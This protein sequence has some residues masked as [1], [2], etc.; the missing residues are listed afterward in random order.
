MEQFRLLSSLIDGLLGILERIVKINSIRTTQ[1]IKAVSPVLEI[2]QLP[3]GLVQ[4]VQILGQGRS[5]D[6][7]DV[8]GCSV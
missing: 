7:E 3:Q 2:E 5:I 8:V 6:R 1:T 4:E